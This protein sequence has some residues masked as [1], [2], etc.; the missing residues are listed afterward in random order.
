MSTPIKDPGLFTFTYKDSL[1]TES[2]KTGVCIE[3]TYE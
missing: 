1:D 2:V 3:Q